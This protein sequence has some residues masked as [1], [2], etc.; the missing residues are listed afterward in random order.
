MI[1]KSLFHFVRAEL[2][3]GISAAEQFRGDAGVIFFKNGTFVFA[4][5]INGLDII[6]RDLLFDHIEQFIGIALAFERHIITAVVFQ[7]VDAEICRIFLQV[8]AECAE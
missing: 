8:F 1:P 2:I 4:D 5:E 7:A 3:G 6:S